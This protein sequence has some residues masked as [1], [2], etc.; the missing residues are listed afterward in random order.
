MSFALDKKILPIIFRSPGNYERTVNRRAAHRIVNVRKHSRAE[1]CGPEAILLEKRSHQSARFRKG[2]HMTSLETQ[3]T[4]T[5]SHSLISSDRIDGTDVYGVDRNKIGSIEELM[6]DKISGKVA[7][8]VL[9]FGGFLGMGD[10]HY[11][12]PWSTLKYDTG[13]GGYIVNL[14]RDQLDKA[15]KYHPNEEWDWSRSNDERLHSY[16]KAQPYWGS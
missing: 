8:A 6:I 14:N 7:Y 1:L 13:L 5:S 16:Y 15:P 4:S 10:E 3:A 9:S 11:P 12:L 2:T